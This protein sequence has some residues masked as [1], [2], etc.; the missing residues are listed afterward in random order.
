[1]QEVKIGDTVRFIWFYKR[2]EIVKYGKVIGVE[3]GMVVIK[4]EHLGRA[5]TTWYAPSMITIIKGD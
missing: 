3:L 4:F 5:Y 2:R 1:M